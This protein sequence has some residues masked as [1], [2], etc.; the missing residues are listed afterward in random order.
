MPASGLTVIP[1]L[2]LS[3]PR[4]GG[5]GGGE[6]QLPPSFVLPHSHQSASSRA[7]TAPNNKLGSHV[8]HKHLIM[9]T[10]RH[11]LWQ[12]LHKWSCWACQIEFHFISLAAHNA[13]Q[14][15]IQYSKFKWKWKM[16]LG[17]RIFYYTVKHKPCRRICS[18]LH[19]YLVFTW[20]RTNT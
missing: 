5:T 17:L 7:R 12:P 14:I 10:Y 3:L 6:A 15:K 1:L 8:Q 2:T 4:E 11:T 19:S 20:F 9:Q 16:Y 18:R 13:D